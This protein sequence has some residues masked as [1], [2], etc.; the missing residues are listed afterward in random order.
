MDKVNFGFRQVDSKEKQGLVGQI[1]S[2]VAH[3]YDLM[4]DVMSLG[5]HRLWKDKLIEQLDPNKK[6][7]DMASGTGD[8]A[9]RYYEKCSNPDITLSDINYEMLTTGKNKLVDENIFKGLE[10]ICSNAENL[11]FKE[12]SYD[13]YSIAFGIRNVTN[14]DK[15]LEEAYRVLKPGGKFLCLE[16]SKV[17]N[18]TLAK[19]YDFY[20]MNIIPKMGSMI[21][22]DEESYRYLVES[23][24]TF[25]P[26]KE[27]VTMMSAAGFKHSQY[28]NLT[29]G[30]ASLYI[31]YKS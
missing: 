11:P 26:Q 13:Y 29:F 8:I 20:S 16:F 23:I 22:G 12:D 7:L 9:K 15:A 18:K 4:N 14:I 27:F 28:F 17:D 1:F 3:K 19:Y 21:A 6:L 10:F 2:S 30:V 24:R 5:I 31:G 25:P